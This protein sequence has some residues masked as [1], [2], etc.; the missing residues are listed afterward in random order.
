[1]SSV[2]S[3]SRLKFRGG[4]IDRALHAV[5]PAVPHAPAERPNVYQLW[6]FRIGNHPV[7]P[8]EVE[9]W[10]ARPMLPAIY[11]TP[12]RR[13]KSARIQQICLA[14]IDGHIVNMLVA[15]QHA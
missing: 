13:F 15:I 3:L 10:D 14:R 5:Y 6:I 11:R 2:P 4:N 8:F 12:C 1:M 9:A 7:A